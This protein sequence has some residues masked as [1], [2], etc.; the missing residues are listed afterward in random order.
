MSQNEELISEI[1]DL[2][3][4]KKSMKEEFAKKELQRERTMKLHQER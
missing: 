4:I 3:R 1:N 2:K